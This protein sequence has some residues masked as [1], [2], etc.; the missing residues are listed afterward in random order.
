MNKS[1][2]MKIAG[3]ALLAI[4]MSGACFASVPEIDPQSGASALALFTGA[5]LIVR[6]RR[7]K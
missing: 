5:L 2:A 3:A 7:R 6:G 4:G 1:V